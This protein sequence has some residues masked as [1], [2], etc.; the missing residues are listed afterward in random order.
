MSEATLSAQK[1][2]RDLFIARASLTALVP[3]ESIRDTNQLPSVFP[4]IVIGEAQFVADDATCLAAGEC[5]MTCH[6]YT[7]EMGTE[8]CKLIVGEIRRA[9]RD[10]SGTVDGFAIDAFFGDVLYLRDPDGKH[11]HGVVSIM[12]LAEDTLAGVV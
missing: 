11:A 2:L 9:V 5:H 12:C 4:C 6:V 8:N 7:E 1:F 3:A 10:Q